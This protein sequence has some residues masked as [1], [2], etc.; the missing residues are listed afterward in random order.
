MF[1]QNT[2]QAVIF[3]LD[4]VLIDTEWL[5]FQA[6]QKWAVGHGGEL[7]EDDYTGLTGLTAEQSAVYVMGCTGLI[8]DVAESSTWAWQWVL[9]RMNEG[10]P[11]LP[12]AR[13]LVGV[14]AAR[15][16]PLAIASN[17]TTTHVTNVLTGLGMLQSFPIRVGIDQVA[18]GKP[19]P[20]VYLRAA[21]SL[22]VDPTR[23]LAIEDSRVGVQAACS[24][25]MRVIAVPGAHD[26]RGGFPGA[27]KIYPS[28]DKVSEDLENI[29]GPARRIPS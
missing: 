25:G 13:E 2:I 15:G 11:P 21:H 3:D 12:G 29:L 5:A 22:G 27:W 28:L 18:Q 17:S 24:A 4:G 23:C 14:L 8:F 1:R 20:G 10:G 9:D 19:A 7:R 6:W 26:H 16:Y